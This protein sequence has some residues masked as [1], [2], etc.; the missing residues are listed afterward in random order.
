MGEIRKENLHQSLIEYLDGLGLTEEQVNAIVQEA[1]ADVNAKDLSQDEAMGIIQSAVNKAQGEVDAVELEVDE[2]H[3]SLSN[4][5]STINEIN[6][7]EL[8]GQQYKLT[9]DNG[10]GFDI[11]NQDAD[12]CI[13]SG[14]IYF[15]ENIT[16]SPAC[17]TGTWWTIENYITVDGRWG[18]QIATAWHGD[19][20]Y[21]R[22]KVNGTFNGWR[23]IAETTITDNL[24]NQLNNSQLVKMTEDGGTCRGIPNNNANDI[25][26]TGCWMGAD[27]VNGPSG[28]TGQW[29]YL[30]SFV[31]NDLYQM[32]RAT[33]LHNSS[34]Q[35][36]RHKTSGVWS[37]WVCL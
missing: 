12:S 36:V 15:G 29:I 17:E 10:Q 19:E 9:A 1:L 25:N 18:H 37:S 14:T 27:V 6:T 32:Q 13:G 2:L 34:I 30:E 5:W 16:N 21:I 4:A 31:H 24:Q 26:T 20:M 22:R 8:N 23:R 28:V 35:W 3:T 33:D 7:R 11:S